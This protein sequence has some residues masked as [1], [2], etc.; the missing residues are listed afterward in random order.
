M[1]KLLVVGLL[2]SIA[3]VARA[4][5]LQQLYGD[6]R[7]AY[8]ARDYGRY[9]SA[10]QTLAKLRPNHPVVLYNL[11]GAYALN[12]QEKSAVATLHRLAA[13][14]VVFDLDAEHDFD[15]I[16]RTASFRSVQRTMTRTERQEVGTGTI[17][18]KIP[19]RDLITEGIAYDGASGA[20]FVSS[21]RMKRIL[22]AAPDG[23]QSTWYDGS[24]GRR[25]ISGMAIDAKRRVLWAASGA[26]ERVAGYAK[27]DEGDM[28]LMQF[29]V[30]SGKVI[31]EFRAPADTRVFFDDVAAAADGTVY[32]SDSTGSIFRKRPADDALELFVAKGSIRSPQGMAATADGR[33]LYVADYGG[34][35]ARVD[36]AS[37]VVTALEMPDNVAAAGIDG[38][39]LAGT[40]TLFAVQNGVRPNRVVRLD[41]SRDGTRITRATIVEMNHPLMD[42]PTLGTVVGD[43]YYWIGASQGNKFESA[44]PQVEKLHEAVVY[45][46]KVR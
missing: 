21:V 8:D 43:E 34:R 17:A 28:A 30:D 38:L 16:R 31:R 15:A 40:S 29:D 2:L 25:G 26:S 35:I 10:M 37:A 1:R 22:R 11:A 46:T 23:T 7:A 33:I 32:V 5:S 4:Q 6:A 45:K 41:L 24:E 14:H 27:S 13:M 44:P 3:T 42:E 36:I 9:L 39:A 18:F 12:H 19:Q 20:F